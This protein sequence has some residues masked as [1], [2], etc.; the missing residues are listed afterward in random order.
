MDRSGRSGSRAPGGEGIETSGKEKSAKEYFS[1]SSV[2]CI[3]CIGPYMEN[4]IEVSLIS[5]Y[6]CLLL[7]I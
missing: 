6:E 7:L 4:K 2:V 3:V 1:T 5:V